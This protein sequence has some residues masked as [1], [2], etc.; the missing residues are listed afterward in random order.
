MTTVQMT[1]ALSAAAARKQARR[2]LHKLVPEDTQVIRILDPPETIK[3]MQPLQ[4]N[5]VTVMIDDVV[6]IQ[7]A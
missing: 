1:R 3:R 7:E 5:T 2:Y 4:W 6:Y